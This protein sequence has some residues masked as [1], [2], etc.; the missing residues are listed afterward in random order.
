MKKLLSIILAVTM[1]TGMM[2]FSVVAETAGGT[3]G[4]IDWTLTEDGT[5][6]IAPT[7]GTPVPDPN[8]GK[9]FEVGAWREAVR[10]DKNGNGKAIEGWPYDRTKVKKLVIEEGVTSI[11]SFTAQG[12]TNL[13]G[14]VVIPSTVTYIGQEAFMKSTFTSLTFAKGGT[15]E[16]CIA[17]GAFKNLIIEEVA[18]PDDRPVHIHAWIFNNCHNLKHATLPASL[19]SVHGTNHIEY[20]G[21]PNTH[22]NPTWTKSSEI[23]AYNEN[24][25]TITFGSEEVRDMF[26]VKSSNGTDLD[27][28]KVYAGLTAYTSLQSAMENANGEAIIPVPR[29]NVD[30]SGITDYAYAKIGKAYFAT[31]E[32][33]IDYIG[34][35][36][37]DYTIEILKDIEEDVTVTQYP[38]QKITITGVESNARSIGD[39]PVISGTIEIDGRSSNPAGAALTIENIIF[40]AAGA[41]GDAL[42]KAGTSNATRYS[43]NVTISNCDFVDKTA[44][45]AVVAIKQYT[46]G[47]HNWLVTGCTATGMHSLIQVANVEEGF[48]I[49]NCAITDCKN[50]INLN[51]TP[52]TTITNTTADVAGYAVRIGQSDKP[53]TS[54]LDYDMLVTLENNTFTSNSTEDALIIARGGAQT[55][56]FVISSGTYK[57]TAGND[58]LALIEG[59][60]AEITGGTY[61]SVVDIENIKDGY[62]LSRN[63]SGYVVVPT[64]ALTDSIYVLYEDVTPADATEEKVYGIVVKANDGDVINQLETVDL[65]FNLTGKAL[66]D[67]AVTFTVRP[68]DGFTMSQTGK[69][70]EENRY[71]FNYSTL[72]GKWEGTAE[73]ITVG[74][75]TVGGYGEYAI[76]TNAEATTNLVNATTYEDNLVDSFTTDGAIDGKSNTGA[77]LVN[78]DDKAGDD[79]VAAVNGT[80]EVPTYALTIN[81]D[82]N[83]PILKNTAAYQDMKVEIVGGVID[84]EL[85]LGNTDYTETEKYPVTVKQTAKGYVLT[86]NL[87]YNTSYAVTVSGAGYRTAYCDNIKL[88]EAKTVQFWN[89]VMSDKNAL[90]V[91]VGS[92]KKVTKNFL[93]GE[94]VKDGEINIYDLSAVVSYFGQNTDKTAYSK[95]AK[96]DLNRDGVI[97]S[98]D[99]AYVL[100]SWNE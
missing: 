14:E 45:K 8:S 94:V 85:T 18:L 25:E 70:G 58:V 83:N 52:A 96:Y 88:T 9:N 33:A 72:N 67:G 65:L 86:A 6:T 95:Y 35:E 73:A 62:R 36:A 49:E 7:A 84:K 87:P 13:T 23:F 66:D 41:E 19:K 43:N 46:G 55:A 47:C 44:S 81:I 40:D 97:D 61:S 26:F 89:N 56:D 34:S 99:V 10:Y 54:A 92:G 71:M 5:L 90:E 11:G 57:N 91:L 59:S 24:M 21:N 17:H 15:E 38:N 75:I 32:S 3:W 79:Y 60:D 76:S 12:Y 63:A 69:E 1:L 53:G 4:G 93:A 64:N 28:I 30:M 27:Y 78:K 68:A 20:L 22:A 74:Y 50:G 48:V 37:G 31:L 80:I 2:S 29:K 77:L 39:K 82:F 100:V 16:L 51:N 42:I 98:K